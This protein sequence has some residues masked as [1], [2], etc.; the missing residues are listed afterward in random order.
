MT[1]NAYHLFR[2]HYDPAAFG[3]RSGTVFAE[4]MRAEGIPM[5]AG[6]PLPLSEHEV[7]TQCI[8]FIRDKLGLPAEPRDDC[9]VCRD[10]CVNGLWLP[11]YTLLSEREDLDDVAAAANK[12][13]SAWR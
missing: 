7:V 6:Y 5:S 9:P 10:V 3:G 2:V 1:L 4:A 13:A 8:D 12:V 11:Q